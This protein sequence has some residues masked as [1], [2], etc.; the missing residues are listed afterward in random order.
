M[1]TRN[2]Y[3]NITFSGDL[4]EK[5]RE[6]IKLFKAKNLEE[7]FFTDKFLD[8]YAEVHNLLSKILDNKD[9]SAQEIL[10]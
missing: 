6:M 10:E 2:F 3:K 1:P 5:Y 9:L 8:I 7:N 4:K